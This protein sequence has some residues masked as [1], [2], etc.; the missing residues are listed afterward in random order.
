LSSAT[1]MVNEANHNSYDD[2]HDSSF[3]EVSLSLIGRAVL[4]NA[5][6]TSVCRLGLAADEFEGGCKVCRPPNDR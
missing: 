2:S 6:P 5:A 3:H 1:E 4:W